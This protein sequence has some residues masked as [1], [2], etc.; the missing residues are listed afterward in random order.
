[1]R[2]R[3]LAEAGF[4]HGFSLRR[5]GVSEA[6]FSDLNLARNVGDDPLA[7]AENHRRFGAE[8]GY[9]AEALFEV[10]QVHGAAVA[11]VDGQISPDL[12]RVREA[13]A[14]LTTVAGLAI[15]IR[16]ADCVPILV[17]DPGTGAVL[18]VHAGWRGVVADVLSQAVRALLERTGAR[19]EALLA[20]IGPHI[21]PAAFEVG[22]EVAHALA[23]AIPEQPRVVIPR[24]PR[25]HA[26]LGLGVRAQLLRLGLLARHVESVGG[27][28]YADAHRFFSFRRDGARAGRHLAAIVAG[29]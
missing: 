14:L 27:C 5:G 28:T 26:D 6:P 25:P 18:A 15:G 24:E 16:V 4:R 7:V 13:D 20:A 11:V 17:A 2:S 3:L 22:D 21:G 10:S 19:P 29:C 1:L 12:F 8:V 9:S 23:H